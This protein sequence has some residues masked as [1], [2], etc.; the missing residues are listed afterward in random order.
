MSK[1]KNGLFSIS[2]IMLLT[3]FG[4][5]ISFVREAVF[6]AYYGVSVSADAYVIAAQVPVTLFAV[7]GVSLTTT[8][9]P[10]YT[11]KIK[12][13]GNKEANS[14][15]N[16]MI[17]I[18]TII[19]ILFVVIGALFAPEIV[20]IFAPSFSQ[21]AKLLTIKL[22]R[23]I[24]PIVI[25]SSLFNIYK[26]I[27]NAYESFF[28]PVI[29][30]YIQSI[31]ISV[32]IILLGKKFGIYPA[33]IA[34]VVAGALEMFFL[35]YTIRKKYVYKPYLNIFDSEIENVMKLIGPVILGVGIAEVN[36][37]IDRMLASG[38]G[39]GAVASINYASK[40]INV[41]SGL[42]VSGLSVVCFQ[43][44]A[45][46][47]A[48]N[49]IDLLLSQFLKYIKLACFFTIP[50]S[51]GLL[52]MSNE[53]V[54]IV[55]GRGEFNESAVHSTSY[56]FLFYSLGLLFIVLRELGTKVFYAMHDTKTPMFNSAIGVGINIVLNIILVKKMGAAGLALATSISSFIICMLLF[57]ALKKKQQKIQYKRVSVELFKII[58]ASAVM[59]ICIVLSG[60]CLI[61]FNIYLKSFLHVLLGCGVYFAVTF[62]LKSEVLM[63]GIDKVKK[64]I[65]KRGI[66]LCLK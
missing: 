61:T 21:S 59:C 39:A 49:K 19:S 35:A 25:F 27:H 31:V 57:K 5:L 46:L 58:L 41:F 17:S 51:C 4:Q 33:A 23:V 66:K 36:R 56:V 20:N 42:L 15:I 65:T 3:L 55:F 37:V 30:V 44:F 63:P 47:Y 18:F 13:E 12:A 9:L 50:I 1:S 62:V 52:V 10:I 32:A 2:G 38:A 34:T 45:E 54:T 11:K 64:F 8:V 43:K 24:F 40:L 16:N 26:A 22:T 14:F 28:I 6:A 53:A 60:K 29:A 7:V 48:E